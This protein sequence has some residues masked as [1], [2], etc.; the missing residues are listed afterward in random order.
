MLRQPLYADLRCLAEG[1][2]A[3]VSFACFLPAIG[4][5]IS[6][7][8]EVALFGCFAGFEACS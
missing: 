7:W 5:S 2:F 4:L 1:L 8:P 6:F 3:A